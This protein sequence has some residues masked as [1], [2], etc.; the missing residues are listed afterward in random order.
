MVDSPAAA[1]CDR[2]I[3]RAGTAK[4]KS[5]TLMKYLEISPSVLTSNFIKCY[6]VVEDEAP[7]D[8]T[9]TIV[10]DGRPELIIN[11][12]RPFQS[13]EGDAWHSQPEFFFVGQITGPMLVR[14]VGPIRTIGVR[15][16]PQ[17]ASRLW[18]R[19]VEEL[20]DSVVAVDDVSR[21]LG[22][23][24]E[25]LR[26][27]PSLSDQIAMLDQIM[28]ALA[29]TALPEDRAVSF[30]VSEI[31]RESGLIRIGALADHLSLSARQFER[32]FKHQVGI[33]PKL[34]G[35]LQR[36]QRVLQ[37]S[38]NPAVNWVD[39]AV[40][41]GYYDQAHLIRDFRQFAGRTPSALLAEEFDLTRNFIEGSRR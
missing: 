35:R 18:R 5:L 21:T 15:F 38:E 24:L 29:L 4:G 25:R 9:Q 28:S 3:P 40:H 1:T 10:P 11:L 13:R 22:R 19:P 20:T 6:W 16:L 7:A 41:H 30:A 39:T 37:A 32:R 12:A 27:L 2:C 26:E 33:A 14:P 36:F 17:G 31:E 34:F 8:F 23:Q